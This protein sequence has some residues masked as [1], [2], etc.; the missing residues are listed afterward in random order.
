MAYSDPG[1]VLDEGLSP[2]PDRAPQA[3]PAPGED[4]LPKSRSGETD[5][6]Q[7][8]D[9]DRETLARWTSWGVASQIFGSSREKFTA[10][11][12]RLRELLADERA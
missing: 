12:E 2:G 6:Q 4:H 8:T 1:T 9:A 10:Q 3:H 5:Q 11:A 7:A